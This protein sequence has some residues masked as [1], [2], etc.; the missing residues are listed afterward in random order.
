[1]S[2]HQFNGVLAIIDDMLISLPA[3]CSAML[4]ETDLSDVLN[5]MFC[6]FWWIFG[7]DSTI[8]WS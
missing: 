8:H 6:K 2:Q 3:M 5:D 4:D 7:V 1:M